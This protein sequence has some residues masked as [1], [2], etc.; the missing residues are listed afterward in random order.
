[1]SHCK[2]KGFG[3]FQLQRPNRN[4]IKEEIP[5]DRIAD[6]AAQIVAGEE[7]FYNTF[8][9]LNQLRAKIYQLDCNRYIIFYIAESEQ[10]CDELYTA[11]KSCSAAVET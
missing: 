2:L 7:Y 8:Y 5:T 1:M 4:R 6:A 11:S 10:R 3:F 9:F